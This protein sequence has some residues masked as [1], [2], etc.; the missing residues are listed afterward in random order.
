MSQILDGK[1]MDF[2][3]SMLWILDDLGN[4]FWMGVGAG[5]WMKNDGD[6][7]SDGCILVGEGKLEAAVS[8]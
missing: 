4:G 5:F 6:F 8:I 7:G 2:G 3:C 1:V